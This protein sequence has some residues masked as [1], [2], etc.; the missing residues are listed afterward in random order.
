MFILYWYMH[1]DHRVQGQQTFVLYAF[2]ILMKCELWFLLVQQIKKG[3][4]TLVVRT[5]LRVGA[6]CGQTQVAQLCRSRSLSSTTGMNRVS[7]DMGDCNYLNNSSNTMSILGQPAKPRD[8]IMIE[9]I[10]QKGRPQGKNGHCS[11]WLWQLFDHLSFFWYFCNQNIKQ[12][13]S[14]SLTGRA[15]CFSQFLLITNKIFSH[16]VFF[17]YCAKETVYSESENVWN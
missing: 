16:V 12:F 14:V 8:R 7:A 15:G 17:L 3:L 10:L 2:N 9:I 13:N 5:S 6:L 1:N 11:Y 4:L